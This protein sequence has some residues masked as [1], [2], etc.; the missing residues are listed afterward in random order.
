MTIG[1][2]LPF[3]RKHYGVR[4][5]LQYLLWVVCLFVR[6]VLYVHVAYIIPCENGVTPMFTNRASTEEAHGRTLVACRG[7]CV[8]W[9]HAFGAVY[10]IIRC[11]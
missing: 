2:C 6:G 3:D 5:G 1:P 8:A 10:V 4:T 11:W 7:G 9:C